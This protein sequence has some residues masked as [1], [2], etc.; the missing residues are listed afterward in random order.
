MRK[1]LIIDTNTLFMEDVSDQL[2]FSFLENC[3]IECTSDI[4]EA[5][6]M[7]QEE[8]YDEV[9][10]NAS[11][12]K[13]IPFSSELPDVS[14]Y[15]RNNKDK[16]VLE[17]NKEFPSYGMIK[18]AS[19][20][21]EAIDE[22]KRTEVISK[23]KSK[24]V[25]EEEI[26]YKEQAHEKSHSNP[27]KREIEDDFNDDDIY[28]EEIQTCPKKQSRTIHSERKSDDDRQERPRKDFKQEEKPKRKTAINDDYEDEIDDN[29]DDDED[30]YQQPQKSKKK[31]LRLEEATDDETYE[32][33]PKRNSRM[34]KARETERA[35]REQERIEQER[36]V[37]KQAREQ[38][39]KDL[40]K[41]K[42]KAHVVTV[43]SAKGGVGKTTISCE[44]ATY[45]SLIQHGQNKLRICI[46]DFNIDFGDVGTTLNLSEDGNTMKEWAIDIKGMIEEGHR[47]EDITFTAPQIEAYLQKN[48]KNGL[49][50]LVSPI[51]NMDSMDITDVEM[52][53]MLNNLIN[54]GN[55]DFIVCDTGNNTRDSTVIAIEKADELLLILTQDVNTANCNIRALDTLKE[56]GIKNLENAKLIINK[57][58]ADKIVG[59][60]IDQLQKNVRDPLTD[61]KLEIY[62]V[63]KDSNEVKLGENNAEPVVYNPSSDFTKAIGQIASRLMG[64]DFVLEAPKKKKFKLFSWRK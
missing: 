48:E 53:V 58:Q 25:M 39:K 41:T 26:T 62:T 5:R 60:S 44:L 1:V 37:E 2:D 17:E 23:P 54:Y 56:I 57:L 52:E 32:P 47:P 31:S 35:R 16:E 40:G 11:C 64:E 55:F 45:L 3:E 29:Y 10:V 46:A 28:E 24:P 27:N 6:K 7:L 22:Q 30:L 9:V 12:Y 63:I 50:A 51:S 61:E 15:G 4:N 43:Y 13:S 36:L 33:S 21:V 14:L 19:D 18:Y 38:V 59:L 42:K 20:F 49:Y 34:Q 8:N